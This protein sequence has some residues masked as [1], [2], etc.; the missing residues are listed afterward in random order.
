MLDQLGTADDL[1][2]VVEQIGQELIF[3]RGQLH[4]IAGQGHLARSRVEPDI[5]CDQFG[6]GVARG[7]ADQRAQAG[8]QFLGLERLGDIIVGAGIEA[9]Y[10]VRPAVAR[11]QH[12]HRGSLA[13]FAPAVENGQPVDFRQTEIEHDRV[14]ILGLSE[15]EA[16]LAV[17]RRVDRITRPFERV[18]QLL[19]EIGFVLDDQ[20][21]HCDPLCASPFTGARISRCGR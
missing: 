8:N 3:L 5:A 12:E 4:R 18:L 2:L 14:V 6:R 11:G 17:A 15:K 1:A 20:N 7:A 13:L 19:A 21:A 9:R 16:F 10:L